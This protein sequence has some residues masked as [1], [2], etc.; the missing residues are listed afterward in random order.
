MG[1]NTVA[2]RFRRPRGCAI[3]DV[4]GRGAQMLDELAGIG[5]QL[6]QSAHA[7]G[8]LARRPVVG[9]RRRRR[10]PWSWR[11]GAPWSPAR[12]RGRRR[13]PPCGRR[14]RS[15]AAAR[16]AAAGGRCGPPCRRG[17]AAGRW[18]GRGRRS[19]GRARRRSRSPRLPASAWPRGTTSDETVGA[20]RIGLEPR[21]YR[22]CRPRC[23]CRRRP[24]RSARRSRRESRS[25]RSTLTCGC[26]ARNALSASGRNSVS[27]LVLDRTR[28]WPARPPA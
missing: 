18:P 6:G 12:C 20:E 1:S 7:D 21:P 8:Q 23:R 15:C 19:R 10:W 5:R 9:E 16:A 2:A 3:P 27:A 25:S 13:I 28:I 17:S 26:A 11:R 4:E 22:R 24:R 14:H